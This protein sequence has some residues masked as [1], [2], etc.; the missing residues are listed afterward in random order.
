MA[1]KPSSG[2]PQQGAERFRVKLGNCDLRFSFECPTKGTGMGLEYSLNSVFVPYCGMFDT[3]P[4]VNQ[5]EA[6]GA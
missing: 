2:N 4:G 5:F 6:R 1:Q 3:E